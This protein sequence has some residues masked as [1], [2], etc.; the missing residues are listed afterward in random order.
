MTAPQGK[1]RPPRPVS[2]MRD[3]Y[4]FLED[5]RL[6]PG[7]YAFQSSVMHLHSLLDG[8]ELAMEMSGKPDS[9]P[10]GP[11]GGFIEWLR[12]QINGQ[13]GSL[14]WG[15]AI[16]LEAGDRGMPAMELFF[17]LLDKFRAETTR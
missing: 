8:F 12:G 4:D 2:E 13:Y 9:T 3:V 7:M 10:F 11:R 15:Y 6:R 5:V 1:R 14:I 17:E 16:E